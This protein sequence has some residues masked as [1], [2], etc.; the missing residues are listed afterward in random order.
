ME[1]KIQQDKPA[2]H[3]GDGRIDSMR[4]VPALLLSQAAASAMTPRRKAFQIILNIFS[5]PF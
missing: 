4:T 5:A 1:N 3:N 2:D